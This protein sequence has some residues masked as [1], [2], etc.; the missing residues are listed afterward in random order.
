VQFSF[1]V[2]KIFVRDENKIHFFIH[3]FLVGFETGF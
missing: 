2:K 3:F 1:L